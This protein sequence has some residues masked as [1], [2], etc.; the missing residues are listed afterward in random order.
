MPTFL[1]LL[2]CLGTLAAVSADYRCL[3]F[4]DQETP[5]YGHNDNN[6]V[7]GYLYEFDCTP[8]YI[9]NEDGSESE[10]VAVQ[11]ENQVS[12]FNSSCK[13]TEIDIHVDVCRYE[14][15]PLKTLLIYKM[16]LNVNTLNFDA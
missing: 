10:F 12:V 13:K 1:F 16:A 8:E 5:V 2:L 9:N 7:L 3:C 6:T 4:Y 11:F 14:K 15:N